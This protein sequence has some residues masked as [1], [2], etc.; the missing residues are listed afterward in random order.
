MD[1]RKES[2]IDIHHVDG[3]V[4][5]SQNQEGGL[6]FILQYPMQ[7]KPAER[8]SRYSKGRIF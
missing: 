2:K 3:D 1:Q 5:I 8:Q 6:T 7:F 4:V